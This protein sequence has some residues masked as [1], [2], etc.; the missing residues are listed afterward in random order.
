MRPPTLSEIFSVAM[1]TS[2]NLVEEYLVILTDT[3][4]PAKN[5]HLRFRRCLSTNTFGNEGV[6]RQTPLET[7]VFVDKHLWKRRCL[8]L[9]IYLIF[10]VCRMA[11][12]V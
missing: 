12:R 4:K 7:K 6:C 11:N 3:T 1:R 9:C 5:K 2:L 10:I 8:F